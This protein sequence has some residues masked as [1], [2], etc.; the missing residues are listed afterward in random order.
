MVKACRHLAGVEPFRASSAVRDSRVDKHIRI[1]EIAGWQ[2]AEQNPLHKMEVALAVLEEP[3]VVT[4]VG[5]EC[6]E[7]GTCGHIS[8]RCMATSRKQQKLLQPCCT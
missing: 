3:C 4:V 8:S 7:E 2:P 1:H 5:Q 6:F